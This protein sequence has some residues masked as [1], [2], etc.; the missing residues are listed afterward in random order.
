MEF[1]CVTT[2]SGACECSVGLRKLWGVSE[3]INGME[4]KTL[5]LFCDKFCK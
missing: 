2:D 1:D 3:L 5:Q 4:I